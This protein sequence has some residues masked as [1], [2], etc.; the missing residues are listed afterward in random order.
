MLPTPFDPH[1]LSV[2]VGT[3]AIREWELL[4]RRLGVNAEAMIDGLARIN[5]VWERNGI[6]LQVDATAQMT[7]LVGDSTYTKG[8][9]LAISA[10]LTSLEAWLDAPIAGTEGMH[11]NGV[12]ALTPLDILSKRAM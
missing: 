7:D 9:V 8:D 10:M 1:T 6:A 11:P 5:R 4:A 3:T 2:P 12:S